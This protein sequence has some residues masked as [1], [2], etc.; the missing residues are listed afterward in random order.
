MR[1]SVILPVFNEKERVGKIVEV[2]EEADFVD[3]AIFVDDGSKDGS[4]EFLKKFEN[5]KIKVFGLKRNHGKGFALSF[6]IR[7]A[8]ERF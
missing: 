6:G 8:K 1:I 7:R 4:F 3:E 5:Q 2:L